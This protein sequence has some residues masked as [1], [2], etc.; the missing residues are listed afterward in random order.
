MMTERAVSALDDQEAARR[1]ASIG[2]RAAF[3]WADDFWGE[4][5]VEAGGWG[6]LRKGT[7]RRTSFRFFD[8]LPDH[9]LF[10]HA[11]RRVKKVRAD[12]VRSTSASAQA[13]TSRSVAPTAAQLAHARG[14]RGQAGSAH[15]PDDA[16]HGLAG[17][18]VSAE[19]DDA[20]LFSRQNLHSS[21]IFNSEPTA[22]PLFGIERAVLYALKSAH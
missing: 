11:V 19:G 13:R 20:E 9:P 8:L 1:C 15:R 6:K 10:S 4:E 5:R 7:T 21:S 12:S 18:R 17:I 22:M 16:Q 3:L 2:K 14:R